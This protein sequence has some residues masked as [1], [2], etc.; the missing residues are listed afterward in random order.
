M[1]LKDSNK[2]RG[3]L[4]LVTSSP[5]LRIALGPENPGFGS[6]NWL[7]VD[8]ANE[9]APEYDVAFFRDAVPAADVIVIFKFLPDTQ[10]L[11]ALRQRSAVVYCPVD[12]YGTAAEIDADVG[13]LRKCDRIVVHCQRLVPYFQ[14]Y[15]RT[16]YIDHHVKYVIPTRSKVVPD[17][18]ILWVGE[19]SNLPPLME[20]LKTH[21]L[22]AELVILT[23]APASQFAQ[24]HRCRFPVHFECWS[25][26]SHLHWLSRCRAAFD[27]KADDFRARH[28]PPAKALDFL[29]SGIPFAMSQPSSSVDHLERLGFK[30]PPPE[31]TTRWLSLDYATACRDFGRM[32]ADRLS[33]SRVG[34]TWK[35]I[36]QDVAGSSLHQRRMDA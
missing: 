27:I 1:R 13:R 6:W 10:S 31:D 18:P 14:S 21:E 34:Q 25:P 3:P 24:G 36:L 28:K 17:G 2:N 26:E 23:N 4:S 20:W 30:I 15:A 8:L 29:A 16:T 9:L 11:T 5:R 12:V 7:A 33:L 32:T 35:R 19:Q 22:P